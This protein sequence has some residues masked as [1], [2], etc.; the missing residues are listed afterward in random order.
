MDDAVVDGYDV[1]VTV[2]EVATSG[3]V[4]MMIEEL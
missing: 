2:D 4:V 3:R 1:A